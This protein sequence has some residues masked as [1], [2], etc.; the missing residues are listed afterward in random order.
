M[1]SKSPTTFL[2]GKGKRIRIR[3]E[4]ECIKYKA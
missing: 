1:S 4:K 2:H 3:T